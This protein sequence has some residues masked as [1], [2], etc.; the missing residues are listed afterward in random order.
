MI[1]KI[2][3]DLVRRIDPETKE[4]YLERISVTV[5]KPEEID[6]MNAVL[7]ILRGSVTP[8]EVRKMYDMTSINS[9]YTWIGK[10]VSQEKVLSL[11][12]QSEE[13]MAGKSKDDQIRDLKAQLRQAKK[14]AEVEKLRAEA[15]DTMITLAEQTFNIPVRKKSG[16]KR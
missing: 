11:E 14:E 7:D 5:K 9:V 1:E 10:Y 12:E 13:D 8:E 16:T 2:K 15:Y 4:S 3:T 6:R